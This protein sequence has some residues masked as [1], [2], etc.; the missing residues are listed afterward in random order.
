[1]PGGRKAELTVGSAA[2]AVH[3]LALQVV[4][5]SPSIWPHIMDFIGVNCLM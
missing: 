3:Q 5:I 1:M 2:A 4:T